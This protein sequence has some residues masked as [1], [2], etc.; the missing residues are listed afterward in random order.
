MIPGIYI[1]IPF[2]R[3]KCDYC[4]FYS[5]DLRKHDCG[6]DS[7]PEFYI[8]K[9]LL[10]IRKQLD[11]L[12]PG[13]VDSIYFGGGTPSLL[14]AEQA[15][16]V[17]R[18]IRS[19]VN[20]PDNA[21]ITLE[22]N[23]EDLI[24]QKIQE[25][26]ALGINRIVLGMQTPDRQSHS[27]IGRASR[28]CTIKD[29]E[30]FMS[31]QG[32]SHCIDIIAGIPGQK[33]TELEADLKEIAILKP[34]HI[35]AYI[36]SVEKGTVLSSRIT[37]TPEF[38][39]EQ[40]TAFETT[41]RVLESAGYRHYEISNFSVPGFESKHNMKYWEFMP[42][43]GFGPGS[44]SFFRGKRFF[45]R[46]TVSEYMNSENVIY[47]HDERSVNS[48]IVEYI[49]TGMR[50]LDGFS[51]SEMEKRLGFRIP[52]KVMERIVSLNN[53]GSVILEKRDGDSRIRLSSESVCF[54]DSVIYNIVEPV[55]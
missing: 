25:Y 50:L 34:E 27:V 35:S 39:N 43:L 44:H 55:L 11:S 13:C 42:Y 1:H 38:E 22:L 15:G 16:R 3:K 21:D 51:L 37:V 31:V 41:T 17:I 33:N 12:N 46:M 32:I 28:L 4:S 5:I 48:S 45:N 40:R 24:M 23:P 20:V 9:L 54:A 29:L 52:D 47:S 8:E 7:V 30:N 18:E 2:C 14:S 10:E 36:L 6:S 53:K 49:M 26:K 19:R